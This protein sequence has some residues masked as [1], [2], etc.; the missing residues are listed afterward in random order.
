[1][2]AAAS[3]HSLEILESK[4]ELQL[5]LNKPSDLLLKPEREFLYLF[6]VLTSLVLTEFISYQIE[7]NFPLSY[8]QH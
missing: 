8:R 3:G 2:T 6:F 5:V 7:D 4:A 1:M